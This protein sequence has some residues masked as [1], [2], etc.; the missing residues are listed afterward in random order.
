M[1]INRHEGRFRTLWITVAG[2]LAGFTGAAVWAVSLAVYQ[3]FMEPPDLPG[4]LTSAENGTYWPRDERQWAILLAFAGVLLI[5]GPRRSAVTAGGT[6]AAI[7]SGADLWLDRVDVSGGAAAWSLGAVAAGGF[8]VTA[9]AAWWWSAGERDGE[10]VRHL[11]VVGALVTALTVG[12]LGNDLDHDVTLPSG[13]SVA[14]VPSEALSQGVA[15]LR[16]G[17]AVLF[18]AVVLALL[19]PRLTRGRRLIAAG[20]AAMLV[21]A[22]FT[23]WFASYVIGSD[24]LAAAAA[25]VVTLVAAALLGLSARPLPVARLARAA[26]ACLV[27]APVAIVAAF[28][29]SV[30]AGE[31]MTRIAADPPVNAADTDA[32]APV[33]TVLL[34]VGVALVGH[35]FARVPAATPAVSHPWPAATAPA[36]RM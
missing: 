27:A 5:A 6:L 9:G 14:R 8:A 32:S 33:L 18:A 13:E 7:W 34:G 11:A 23:F 35:L 4:G 26:V 29:G 31:A 3:P 19:A 17:L 21:A 2:V 20:C 16:G 28:V 30:L 24:D 1:E 22:P 12:V 36:S 15:W 25:L 10:L